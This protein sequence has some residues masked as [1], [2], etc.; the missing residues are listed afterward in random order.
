MAV[1]NL[2]DT[3]SI[4]E[5]GTETI[6]GINWTY[7]KW[8][9]GTAECWANWEVGANTPV[10]QIGGFYY[11]ILGYYSLPTNLFDDTPS[12]F[13]N[14]NYWDTGVFWGSVRNRAKDQFQLMLFRNNNGASTAN[15]AIHAIGTWR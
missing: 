12:M 1:S 14:L 2:K 8:S 7:R 13:F 10:G 15:G 4:I 3:I 9:N 6:S 11:S 5:Q